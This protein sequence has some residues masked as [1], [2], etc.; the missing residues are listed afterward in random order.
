MIVTE[1][2]PKQGLCT[3]T[4]ESPDDLWTLRRLLAPGDTVVTKS[5][6]VSKREGEYSRP[7]KGERVKV[8]IAL[9]VETVSLDSSVDRLRVRGK[10]VEASDDSVTKAGSHSLLISSGQELTLQKEKWTGEDTRILHASSADEGRRFLLVAIDRREAG[11]G[12]LTGSHLTVVTTV[13]SGASGKGGNGKEVDMQPYFRKVVE[14]LKASWREKDVVVLGGPGNTKLTM[15]NW[16]HKDPDLKKNAV[17]VEGFDLSG[18]DG[19]RALVK[20]DGFRKVASD[21][22]LVEV[23]ETVEEAIRRISRGERRIAYAFPRVREAAIVGAVE[24]CV[25]SDDVFSSNI[26]EN[27]LVE[28]LNLIE[29]KGGRVFLCDSSLETGKQVS[30]LGGI[31]ALLRY[32]L[33]GGSPA[34]LR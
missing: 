12:L 27:A 18:P 24:K 26:D 4:I 31:V 13:E 30:S 22:V 7:D 5:S 32:D 16:V 9:R 29:E 28:T 21:S 14:I 15:E 19:V 2:I 10:I 34:T 25:V 8:T 33:S 23:Q 3:L 17:L 6:R 20:S 1:F 11:I